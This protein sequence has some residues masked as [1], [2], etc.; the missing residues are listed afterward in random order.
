MLG[1]NRVHQSSTRPAYLIKCE[2]RIL[3]LNDSVATPFERNQ[4]MHT[5]PDFLRS[6]HKGLISAK[7]SHSV[8]PFSGP[9]CRRRSSTLPLSL[10][11]SPSTLSRRNFHSLAS[12]L[13]S[14]NA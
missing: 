7:L 5:T 6:L 8:P 10:S 3:H 1:E 2:T 4:C 9:N 11:F 13:A 12:A 14:P